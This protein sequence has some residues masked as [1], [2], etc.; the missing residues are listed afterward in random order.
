[1]EVKAMVEWISHRGLRNG[2]SENSQLAFDLAIKAGFQWLETDLRC[3]S[4]RQLVLAH[5]PSLQRVF[6]KD[7]NVEDV[8]LRDIELF[9]DAFNQKILTFYDFIQRYSEVNWVLDIKEESAEE[10]LS[11]LS[12]SPFLSTLKE[13]I[14]T[15]IKFLFWS[16]K[17]ERRFLR[18]FP[19]A[20][21]FARESECWRAGLSAIIGMPQ[22]GGF[23]VGKTYAI[24]PSLSGMDLYNDRIFS[25]YKC[26]SSKVL[27][28]LPESPALCAKAVA[29]GADYILANSD[30]FNNI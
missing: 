30:F 2:C 11:A 26:K 12:K 28:Y 29:S 10:T 1:V 18:V 20:D 6:G 8:P 16:V 17:S 13:R 3:T 22:L 14:P 21:T 23:K 25:A 7:V 4:D 15:R 24:P 5:D 27:A 9:T 19:N